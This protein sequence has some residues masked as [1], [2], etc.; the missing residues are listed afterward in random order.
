MV[1]NGTTLDVFSLIRNLIVVC[2]VVLH[3]EACQ[4][5]SCQQIPT[6][7]FPTSAGL[8]LWPVHVLWSVLLASIPKPDE[9]VQ[10]RTR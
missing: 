3:L 7:K 6:T 8:R 10:N 2:T 1:L 5:T 4:A 9:W